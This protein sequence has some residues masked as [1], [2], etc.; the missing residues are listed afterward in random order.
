MRIYERLS[1]VYDLDLGKFSQQYLSLINRLFEERGIR[2]ARILD[3]ACGTGTLAMDLAKCG[4]SVH[5]IDISPEMIEI[6]KSKSIGLSS[7]SFDVQDMTQFRAGGKFDL[8]VCTF[9]SVNYLPDK[10]SVRAMFHRVAGALRESGIFVFDSN[11][12]RLYANAGEGIQEHEL[13]GESFLQKFSYDPIGRE[14]T[15]IFEFS[16]G[17]IEVHKQRPYDLAEFEPILADTGMRLVHAFS[18]FDERPYSSESERLICVAE[19][20]REQG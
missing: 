11:T 14:A 15:I 6:A 5:G 12:N 17:A 13:S 10:D 2:Q 16:D 3:L 7:T 18:G 1:Q 8:V 4:H 20:S 9:D 19:R